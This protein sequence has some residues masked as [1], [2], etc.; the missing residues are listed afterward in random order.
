MSE[1]VSKLLPISWRLGA[2]DYGF[3]A[4]VV[5]VTALCVGVYLAPA[6]AQAL[7]RVRH[8]VFD[9]LAYLTA[10]F[11][12]VDAMHLMFNLVF[13]WLFGFLLYF[14][15]RVI[16]KQRFFLYALLVLFTALPLI[17]YSLLFYFNVYRSGFGFGLSLVDSGLA[18]LTVPSLIM[19]F[20][21]KLDGF[22][23]VPFLASMS[24]L[25][26]LIILLVYMISLRLVLLPLAVLALGLFLGVFAFKKIL[27]FLWRSLGRK[28]TIV[29]SYLLFLCFLLY[30]VSITSLFPTVTQSEIGETDIVSH[31]IGLLFGIIPFSLYTILLTLSRSRPNSHSRNGKR[32]S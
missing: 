6:E 15:N 20:R 29:E 4:A 17:D 26:F 5:I 7:L 13:F 31:Y 1:S 22:K 14:V 16:E 23:S 25:T 30:F 28:E 11:V 19:Y 21:A 24:L 8:G 18:G 3:V 9:P 2:S 32:K 12:H 27:G 10:S